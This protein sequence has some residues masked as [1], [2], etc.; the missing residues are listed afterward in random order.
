MTPPARGGEIITEFERRLNACRE[1]HELV[2]DFYRIGYRFSFELPLRQRP[3]RFPAGVL[4][5]DRRYPWLIWVGWEL[6][7]R[8]GV[9]ALAARG[10]DL[11]H[12]RTGPRADWAEA[13][14][15]QELR[16]LGQWSGFDADDGGAGLFTSSLAASCADV[17]EHADQHSGATTQAAL[18]VAG[19]ILQESVRPW[20]AR[21]W[22]DVDPGHPPPHLPRERLF[23]N[24]RCITLFRAAQLA[25][26]A[27]HELADLLQPKAAAVYTSWLAARAGSEPMTEG[28]AYDGFLL[29]SMLAWVDGRADTAQLRAAGHAV[30]AGIP[31]AWAANSAPGRADLLAPIGDVEPQMMHW[32]SV[33]LRLARWYE[34]IEDV[35]AWFAE[36]PVRRLL[37]DSLG[38]AYACAMQP[39]PTA[40]SGVDGDIQPATAVTRTGYDVDDIAVVVSTSRIPAPHLHLDGGHLTLGWKHRWWITD[41][42]YQQYRLGD[43]RD[44]T[45]GPLAHNAPVLDGFPQAE[46]AVRPRHQELHAPQVELDLSGCYEGLPAGARV[47]REVHLR[48]GVAVMVDRFAGLPHGTGVDIHWHADTQLTWSFVQGAARLSD[49]DHALWVVTGE[50]TES[51]GL[52][53]DMLARHPGT[54]GPLRLDH[55]SSIQHASALRW[56]AFIPDDD[57]GWQRPDDRIMPMIIHL[58]DTRP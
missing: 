26:A 51:D 35:A 45:I 14:L 2:V 34:R 42:G 44:F 41:P 3:E 19:R 29:Q 48:D 17:L 55:R 24:I 52:E 43:E 27:G 13:L 15:T 1:S 18:T 8:W 31:Q 40:G 37:A 22:A 32:A 50:Q 23:Q 6:E 39:A 9:L 7:E 33:L 46:R 47:T 11:G 20:F 25:S 56:W 36:L 53:A 21:T 12:D 5:T 57:G 28:V 58:L 49:G 10:G 4:G 54:R 16:A 38:D 30:L